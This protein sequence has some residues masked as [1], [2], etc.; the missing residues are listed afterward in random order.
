[1]LRYR[2]PCV[3][4]VTHRNVSGR[5]TAKDITSS[6]LEKKKKEE[7]GRRNKAEG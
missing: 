1:M 7:E 4:S 2:G 5:S 6:L 3:I